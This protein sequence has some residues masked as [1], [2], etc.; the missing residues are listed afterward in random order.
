MRWGNGGWT[1]RAA[2]CSA[3]RSYPASST[4]RRA[5]GVPGA[6]RCVLLSNSSKEVCLE[7]PLAR[8]PQRIRVIDEVGVDLFV[9]QARIQAL[10]ERHA[11]A[12]AVQQVFVAR[13]A[14]DVRERRVVD[15]DLEVDVVEVIA[16]LAEQLDRTERD[17]PD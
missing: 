13:T 12:E 5:P 4:A 14:V 17:R 1:S 9:L 15:V 11:D 10:E 3:P 6:C 7:A 16:D 8:E 2:A